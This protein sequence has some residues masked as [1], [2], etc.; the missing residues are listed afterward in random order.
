[1]QLHPADILTSRLVLIALTPESVLAEQ[2]SAGD[3]R[4]F[5]TL[6]GC[7]IHPEWPPIH[8]EPHVFDFFLKQFSEHSEQIGWN[9]YVALP[10]TDGTRTLIGALGAFGKKDSAGVCEIGYGILPSFE[11]KGYATEGML[12]VIDL[13]RRAE[14]VK[15]V[16]AHT[17]PSLQ[18]SIR[19]MEKCGLTFNGTGEEEGT[20]RYRM[21]LR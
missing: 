15:T 7:N 19:V 17:F 2:A 12:A 11:G 5:G 1:M 4:S 8:W 3:Y 16:I 18:R 21:N 13:L 6:I 9:R 14:S 20:I 10:Q